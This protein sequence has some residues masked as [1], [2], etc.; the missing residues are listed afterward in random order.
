MVLNHLNSQAL[1]TFPAS[2]PQKRLVLILVMIFL[3]V[4]CDVVHALASWIF[5]YSKRKWLRLLKPSWWLEFRITLTVLHHITEILEADAR[6]IWNVLLRCATLHAYAG[7]LYQLQGSFSMSHH[8][9]QR[10]QAGQQLIQASSPSPSQFPGSPAPSFLIPT[11]P[12]TVFSPN[13]EPSEAPSGLMPFVAPS[14][15]EIPII[16]N[17]TTPELSGT[18]CS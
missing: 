10:S 2:P 4:T 13:Y 6:L 9:G 7:L 11:A 3:C 18:H 16:T 14:P 8:H 17:P 1:I 15:L 5:W 12:P